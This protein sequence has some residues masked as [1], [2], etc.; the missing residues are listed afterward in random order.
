[1]KSWSVVT[2]VKA[3]E[4]LTFYGDICFAKFCKMILFIYQVL[5]MRTNI[6]YKEV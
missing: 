2:H 5:S 6:L 3:F 1:M 4:Q